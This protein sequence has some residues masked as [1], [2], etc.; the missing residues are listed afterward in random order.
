MRISFL[1]HEFFAEHTGA[2]AALNLAVRALLGARQ[3]VRT[4]IQH[5]CGDFDSCLN[6]ARSL[7]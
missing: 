3:N 2:V 6:C 5:G 7:H 1:Y 4:S